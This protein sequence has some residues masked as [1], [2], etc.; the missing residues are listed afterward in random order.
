MFATNCWIIAD[1]AGGECVVVDPGMPDVSDT[2]AMVLG[3]NNLKPVAAI[4]THGHLDHTFS[5]VP[6]ADGYGIPTYIHSE[7]RALLLHPER[8][9]GPEFLATLS[10]MEFAEPNDVR[11][12]RHGAEVEMLGMKFQAIHSPGHTRGSL[13]FKVDEE[14]LIS[15][16]VLF[17]G[18]IGRTD[19]PSGSAESMQDTL[20]NKVLTLADDLRV[21]P[22]H[23]PDTN[24]GHERKTNP[25]LIDAAK[26]SGRR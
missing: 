16:D 9:H 17:A 15:G 18:A 14:V 21:L 20:V 11:E 1:K 13:M 12:L 23:G 24:I 25:Y 22:G 6:I 2:L 3:E 26:R 10:A 7:D 4:I 8:A 5:I 19:L